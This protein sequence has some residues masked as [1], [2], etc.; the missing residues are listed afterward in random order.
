MN[1]TITILLGLLISPL[2]MCSQDAAGNLYTYKA[3][4]YYESIYLLEDG[5]FVYYCKSEF[6]KSEIEGNWQI[7]NDTILVLDSSPQRSK[8]VVS[9]SYKRAKR[10]TFQIRSTDNRIINYHLYLITP[11]EDTLEFRDQFDKTVVLGNYSSFYVVDTK[12]QYSPTYEIVGSKANFFEVLIEGK[13]VFENEYWKYHGEYIIPL[14][15][16][17]KYSNYKLVKTPTTL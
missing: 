10:N 3:P 9:E 12:G 6:L 5:R 14:G 2:I 1:K 13:R 4:H 15:T 17:G 7:R 8:M 16:D 11:T